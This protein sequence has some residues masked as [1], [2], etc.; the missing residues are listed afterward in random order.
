MF[1]VVWGREHVRPDGPRI[2]QIVFTI[3]DGGH[4]FGG[5]YSIQLS[6][7]GGQLILVQNLAIRLIRTV[8][9]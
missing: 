2:H 6:Y 7:E 3:P 8:I 5:R 9:I 4:G 1:K